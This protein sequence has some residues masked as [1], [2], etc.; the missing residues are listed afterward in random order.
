MINKEPKKIKYYRIGIFCTED[1]DQATEIFKLLNS[2]G[3]FKI[4]N[5]YSYIKGSE[6]F[7]YQ[8]YKSAEIK[9]EEREVYPDQLAALK[10][11]KVYEE[12]LQ[13]EKKDNKSS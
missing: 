9:Q 7:Y 8:N 12:L 2:D 6:Y 3:I 13:K 1:I 11:K 4:E 10:A 5:E